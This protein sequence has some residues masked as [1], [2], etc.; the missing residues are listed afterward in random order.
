MLFQFLKQSSFACV[1]QD[2]EDVP[3][4]FEN[5]VKSV[6]IFM[7]ALSQDPDFVFQLV[8]EFQVLYLILAQ[9]LQGVDIIRFFAG[10]LK[11]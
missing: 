9:N 7:I 1:F 5:A 6:H 2:Q 10:H 11:Y 4:L 3:S 8:T